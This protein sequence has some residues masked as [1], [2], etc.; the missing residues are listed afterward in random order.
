MSQRAASVLFT[1]AAD[2]Q[3]AGRLEDAVVAYRRGLTMV[4]NLAAAHLGLGLALASLH[5]LDE[6]AISLRQAAKLDPGLTPAHLA[7]GNVLGAQQD[8]AAAANEFRKVLTRDSENAE[9]IDGLWRAAEH[10]NDFS[11][12]AELGLRFVALRP[13]EAE[14]EWELACALLQTGRLEEGWRWWARRWNHPLFQARRY[15]L[16]WPEWR[17]EPLRGKRIVLWPEQGIGDELMFASCV[18]DVIRTGA[19][20]VLAARAPLVP[21]F[22]RSFPGARVIDC[23]ELRAHPGRFPADYH[24]PVGSL[25]IWFR[26]SLSAFADT[27]SWLV[28]DPARAAVWREQVAALGPGLKVGLS[29]RSQMMTAEREK[30]YAALDQW[31]PILTTPGMQFVNLQYDG[32]ALGLA[33]AEARFGLRVATWPDLDLKNDFDGTAALI[34]QLDLVITMGNAVGELAGALGRPVWRLVPTRRDWTMLGTAR[35]PWYPSMRVFAGDRSST[36]PMLI[37]RV[38]AAL[39]R[40]ALD[41]AA[42]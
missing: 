28:P 42:A 31:G 7:L 30:F 10:E 32:G 9:A 41:R 33:A 13:G 22:A 34:S 38:A 11:T 35:R 4:P 24:L 26:R 2:L 39:G 40:H 23:A 12:A 15:D 27:S 36:W 19:G 1:S 6:A 21:L 25:P 37:D 29:W 16:P 8:Y 5:R 14:A 18:D 17:G 3:A 20:V